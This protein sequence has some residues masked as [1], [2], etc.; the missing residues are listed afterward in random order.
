MQDWV[1][2]VVSIAGSTAVTTVIG[3]LVKRMLDKYF[4]KKDKE[5][6][7]RRT[8]LAE[9]EKIKEER[10]RE[11][12][13]QDVKQI[14]KE[15]IE[16]LNAKVDILTDK[17]SKTEEGTLS[18]LRND[19]LTCYYRCLEK[20]YRGDWDYE[21]IHHLYDAYFDLNG[22]LVQNPP[23]FHQF[24]YF[25][26]KNRKESNFIISRLGRGEYDRNFRPLLGGGVRD[27]F[28]SIGYGILDSTVC[29]FY[30][31]N[32]NSIYSF[33]NSFFFLLPQ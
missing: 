7:D 15:E 28:S 31:I 18:S 32:D 2:A 19:I 33:L 21:N 25:Y 3:F 16:P 17:V 6:E 13:R 22:K 26:Y 14:V 1:I 23:K 10:L 20:G 29:D 11:E 24:K 4:A 5:E 8:A 9:A 12:R 30:L 27:Y